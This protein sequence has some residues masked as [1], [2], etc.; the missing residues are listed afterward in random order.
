MVLLGKDST[1]NN[2]MSFQ[3]SEE[4]G[5]KPDFTINQQ[6]REEVWGARHNL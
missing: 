6:H 2:Q 4:L 1:D 3:K 5:W